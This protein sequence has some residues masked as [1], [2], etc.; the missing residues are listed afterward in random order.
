MTVV[1]DSSVVV[2]ALL[3]D[4]PLA[5]WAE[6]ELDR[7]PMIAPHLMP[8]EVTN[9][10]RRLTLHGRITDRFAATAMGHLE[11]MSVELV[12]FDPFAARVWELR[13]TV[14]S[15][16]AWYVALAESL[17]TDLVTL[18]TRVARASGPTCGFRTPPD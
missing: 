8:A 15:Y 3:G 9:V 18:D 17:E 10:I 7:Q 14:T 2:V 13:A 11:A 6:G 12:P 16:D 1:V 5:T 4:G